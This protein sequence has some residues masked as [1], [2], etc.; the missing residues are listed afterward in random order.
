MAGG[1]GAASAA[2][3]LLKLI[4]SQQTLNKERP[5]IVAALEV[6]AVRAKQIIEAG[7][8]GWW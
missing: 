7:E 6:I 3:D 5:E 1:F 8:S 2:Q 4:E